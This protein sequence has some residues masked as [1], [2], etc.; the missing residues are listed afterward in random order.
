MKSSVVRGPW[1]V[2][3][4]QFPQSNVRSWMFEVG[5]GLWGGGLMET[6]KHSKYTKER[7]TTGLRDN[8]PRTT[9]YLQTNCGSTRVIRVFRG[10]HQGPTMSRA[11]NS[12]P[13]V[14]LSE[15]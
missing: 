10:C 3:P 1:S 12:L 8:A 9:D 11:W 2:V 5:C 15:L 13:G 7:R 14:S 6:R 4:T